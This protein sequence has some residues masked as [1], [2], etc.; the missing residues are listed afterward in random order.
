MGAWLELSCCGIS[1]C[2]V[3]A[4]LQALGARTDTGLASTANP[5]HQLGSCV[6][7]ELLQYQ[8]AKVGRWKRARWQWLHLFKAPELS[9]PGWCHLRKSM[10]VFETM[11]SDQTVRCIRWQT[12]SLCSLRCSI[13]DIFRQFQNSH[14]H[15]D[16]NSQVDDPTKKNNNMGRWQTMWCCTWWIGERR[17]KMIL[18]LSFSKLTQPS[19]CCR[20]VALLTEDMSPE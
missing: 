19:Q 9:G 5:Q 14:F 20:E 17:K 6:S 2:P 1:V 7:Y 15:C 11:S 4:H 16:I 3:P 13:A 12:K 10:S 18:N 8:A